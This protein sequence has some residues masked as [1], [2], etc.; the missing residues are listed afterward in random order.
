[1]KHISP[2]CEIIHVFL[3]YIGGSLIASRSL[4]GQ[5]VPDEDIFSAV[6]EAIQRFVKITIPAFGKGWLD[7]IDH[8]TLKILLERGKYCFLVLVTT[9]NQDDQLRGEVRD[10]LRRFEERNV[11]GLEQWNGD[12][13]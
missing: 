6:L 12:P 4:E 2:R 9:G 11:E 5:T 7:A 8:G 3:V 10:V 13:D 1:M